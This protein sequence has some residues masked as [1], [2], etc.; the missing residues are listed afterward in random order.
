MRT[1]V[2]LIFAMLS[3]SVSSQ[4]CNGVTYDHCKNVVEGD[5]CIEVAECQEGYSCWCGWCILDECSEEIHL[6]YPIMQQVRGVI[7]KPKGDLY[8]EDVYKINSLLVVGDPMGNGPVVNINGIQCLTSLRDLHITW[9]PSLSNIAPI[10]HLSSLE[11]LKLMHNDI[12]DI[13]PLSGL[14]GIMELD[15]SDNQNLASLM[16]LANLTNLEDL[17]LSDCNIG[18]ISHLSNLINLGD[19]DLS[20]NRITNIGPLVD[21]MGIGAR[22][23]VSV[24]NNWIDC[25]DQATNIQTLRDRGV[26]L[27]VDCP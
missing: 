22:D 13:G 18:D 6:D 4:N 3:F 2:Y 11:S 16:P 17:G 5:E 19:V 9:N 21:N 23:Y 27:V 12:V 14:H 20:W 7:D 15:L 24:K 8:Y 26:D 25:A 10:A 1:V